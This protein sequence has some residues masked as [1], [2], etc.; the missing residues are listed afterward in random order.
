MYLEVTYFN[1]I[2]RFSR[3]G[4]GSTDILKNIKTENKNV[5]NFGENIACRYLEKYEYEILCRN[6]SCYYGEVDIIFKDKN[7][8]VFC[9]VKTRTNENCGFPAEA[10]NYYKQKHIWNTAKYFLYKNGILNECV[11]FDIIEVYKTSNK[12]IVNHIKNAFEKKSI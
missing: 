3:T 12:T 6:F 11:R 2:R 5:G 1:G 4:G 9:E 10:V 7:E 8:Y